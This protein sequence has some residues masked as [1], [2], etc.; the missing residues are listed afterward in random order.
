MINSIMYII[1]KDYFQ[2]IIILIEFKLNKISLI[3]QN[4]KLKLIQHHQ[5]HNA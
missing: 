5:H 3:D 2:I 1:I 4:T